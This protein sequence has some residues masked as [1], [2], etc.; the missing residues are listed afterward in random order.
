MCMHNVDGTNQA[1]GLSFSVKPPV[2]A[3]P[4]LVNIYKCLKNDYP[5][6]VQPSRSGCLIPWAERGVLML[7]A[8]LTVRA[9][10]AGSHSG[11]GW[12]RLTGKAIEAVAQRRKGGVVFL[13]WG[14]HAEKRVASVDKQRHLVL[15]SAHPSPLSAHRGFVGFPSAPNQC[16]G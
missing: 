3:P 13:A 12:E 8:S 5:S 1:H 11:R 16:P 7:N 2:P 4:S 9:G 6:F 14:A 10:D 15:R